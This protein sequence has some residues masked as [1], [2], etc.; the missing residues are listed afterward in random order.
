MLLE[1]GGVGMKIKNDGQDEEAVEPPAEAVTVTV[2]D[3]QRLLLVGSEINLQP[4]G[5][6]TLVN[7]DTI[8]FTDGAAQEFSTTV[9]DLPVEVRATPVEFTWD[10]GDGSQPLVTTDA[11]AGYPDHTLTHVY[12]TA[13]TVEITLTTSWVGEFRINGIGPWLPVNGVAT[14]VTVS[15]PLRVETADTNLVP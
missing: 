13:E 14:T 10:F 6:W 7:V 12:S 3:F 1:G 9:L 2:T 8:V 15:D 4:Q 5:E 11:G